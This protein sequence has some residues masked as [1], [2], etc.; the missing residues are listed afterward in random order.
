MMPAIAV[1]DVALLAVFIFALV[2]GWQQGAVSSIMAILGVVLGLVIGVPLAP[3]AMAQVEN[4]SGKVLLGLGTVILFALIG[5][6]V[7]TGGGTVATEYHS[8]AA[9]GRSGL[10]PRCHRAVRD[11]AGSDMDD[12]RT[13]GHRRARTIRR[14]G[15]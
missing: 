5:H 12:R 8:L 7:G 15:A 11:C 14:L 10:E 9:G 2:V 4:Q 6:A 1:F 3:L 13:L